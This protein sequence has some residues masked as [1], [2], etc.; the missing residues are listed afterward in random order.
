MVFHRKQLEADISAVKSDWAAAEYYQS[1][2]A[3]ADI[4]YVSVGPV[5]QPTDENK[6]N[7]MAAPEF[8]SG[9]V[10]GMVGFGHLDDIQH[11][12]GGFLPLLP[13]VEEAIK[14]IEAK[15]IHAA[16]KQLELLVAKM[17]TSLAPCT[18]LMKDMYEIEQWAMIFKNPIKLAV[19]STKNYLMNREQINADIAAMKL[20]VSENNYISTGS[21]AAAMTL[22]L[23]GPME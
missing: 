17:T 8:A 10:M 12:A 19:T 3:A 1:G 15:H 16:V 5:P 9:F 23:V 22:T 18:H 20:F 6:F 7:L 2:K 11:C 21:T 13:F 14:D 4:L